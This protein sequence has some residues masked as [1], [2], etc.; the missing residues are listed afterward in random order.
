MLRPSH[1]PSSL[2]PLALAL[3]AACSTKPG[4]TQHPSSPDSRE[5]TTIDDPFPAQAVLE[6]I[7]ARPRP[8]SEQLFG[9]KIAAAEAW[10]L[11]GP[12]ATETADRDYAGADGNAKA[13]ASVAAHDPDG[14]RVTAGM[15]CFAE[16]L[17]RFVLAHGDPPAED[18]EAFIAARSSTWSIASARYGGSSRWCAWRPTSIA[19]S[20]DARPRGSATESS[21]PAR[22]W[23]SCSSTTWSRPTGRSRG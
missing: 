11:H 3:A 4:G 12:G 14:R 17:G 9:R 18:I 7:A 2:A 13:L 21:I 22:R 1:R 19:R 8:A 15:Q 5:Q 20:S 16:E 23:T 6:E 10:T